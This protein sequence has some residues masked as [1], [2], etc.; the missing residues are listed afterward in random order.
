MS[1]LVSKKYSNNKFN[2]QS[3]ILSSNKDCIN[4]LID[5]VQYINTLTS[6][7]MFTTSFDMYSRFND[8]TFNI[9]KENLIYIQNIL[10]KKIMVEMVLLQPSIEYY[11]TKEDDLT[12]TLDF[13]L[14]NQDRFDVSFEDFILNDLINVELYPKTEDLVAF[15]KKIKNTFPNHPVLYQYKTKNK[16]QDNVMPRG[17][18]ILIQFSDKP[19]DDGIIYTDDDLRIVNENCLGGILSN[20]LKYPIYGILKFI[21]K[22]NKGLYCISNKE[23]ASAYFNKKCGFCKYKPFCRPKCFI[24]DLVKYKPQ[25]CQLKP[26][27][28]LFDE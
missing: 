13:L 15:Y 6:N 7:V 22:N 19:F 4:N 8:I 28:E 18:C 24:Q 27:F 14:G 12:K 1:Y 23:E 20:L 17:E 21:P 3:N 9:W 25:E 11:L 2:I 16:A 10:Q 26:L 5:L